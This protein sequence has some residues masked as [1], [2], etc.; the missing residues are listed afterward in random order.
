MLL[1]SIG[2]LICGVAGYRKVWVPSDSNYARWMNVL[3]NPTAAPI[4]MRVGTANNLGSDGDT[5]V[6]TS[7]NGDATFDVTD[8]WIT[9]MQNYSGTT[10]PDPRL[11]HVLQGADAEVGLSAVRFVNNNDNVYWA[12]DVTVQPGEA[13]TLMNFTVGEL[14]KAAA[15]GSAAELATL[16]DS[17]VRCIDQASLST[18][19]NFAAEPPP[20][21]LAA[22]SI[23]E[24]VGSAQ[25]TFTREFSGQPATVAFSLAP[26][27]ATAGTD[28]TVPSVLEATFAADQTTVQVPIAI[29]DDS[30]LEPAESFQ[31]TITGVTGFGVTGTVTTAAIT[32]EANDPY[33]FTAI[34]PFRAGDTREGSGGR[35]AA[36]TTRRFL[37]PNRPANTV[38]ATLNV[39]A[40][41]PDGPGF[42]TLFPCDQAMPPTSNVNYSAGGATPNQATVAISTAGEVCVFTMTGTD[43][44]IDVN[45]W[46]SPVGAGTLL[47]PSRSERVL[48]SR[49][50]L[51]PAG[52]TVV[53]NLASKVP[54]AAQAVSINVT[55]DQ[56]TADGFVTVYPCDEARPNVSNVNQS[57]GSARPNLATVKLSATKT[58]CLFVSTETA[59]IVDLVGSWVP[60]PA[61][62]VIGL[63][64]DATPDRVY[65]SR[66]AGGVLPTGA[67]RRVVPSTAAVLF[68]NVTATNTTSAGYLAAFPC[69]EGYLGTSNVNYG[70]L[71]TSST[72][73]V[74]DASRGG[75]CVFSSQPIDVVVDVF[76]TMT[77]PVV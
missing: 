70:P 46:W 62:G 2:G 42:L 55:T 64:P 66:T 41:G 28:Y 34:T 6:V 63:T 67:T 71:S 52:S 4:M 22:V 45:G 36:G 73:A 11:G 48:D 23:A 12:W 43:V 40:V 60:A 3:H 75:I 37:L 58:V 51:Q 39:T 18:I 21:N 14:S 77:M 69:D 59:L 5:L 9:T 74:I 47:R 68:V 49:P 65:D 50:A 19:V 72:A 61:T 7:S 8:T 30:Q 31:A 32:I 76:A 29:I 10:S 17:A 38:A 13:V 57:P 27:T 20:V 44:V 16:P 26:G 15:A 24:N 35:L 1:R 53:L 25:L 33:R 54:A 56:A